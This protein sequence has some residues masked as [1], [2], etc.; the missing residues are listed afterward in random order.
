MERKKKLC[1]LLLVGAMLSAMLSSSDPIQAA[2]KKPKLNKKSVTLTVGKSVTL[3]LKNNKK[4]VKW[5]TSNRKIAKVNKKGNVTAIAAGSAK[6]TAKAGKKKYQC[7]VRVKVAISKDT[8]TTSPLSNTSQ[9]NYNKLKRYITEKGNLGDAGNKEIQGKYGDNLTTFISYDARNK[10]YVFDSKFSYV[11]LNEVPITSRIKMVISETNL[12]H[13]ALENTVYVGDYDAVLT[14]EAE[15][16]TING[17][18]SPAWT[19]QV[20]KPNDSSVK[21]VDFAKNRWGTSYAGWR[22][23]LLE[24]LQI[25]MDDLGFREN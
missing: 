5:T 15:V 13:V 19:I 16:S 1:S 23:L 4:K 24:T 17:D 8:P 21:W 9:E 6:I 20:A 25:D 7:R 18:N 10:A 3:K 12:N 11:S 22:L 14:S 2:R